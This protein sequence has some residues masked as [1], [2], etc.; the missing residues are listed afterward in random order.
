MHSFSNASLKKILGLTHIVA[1]ISGK[2]AA[3][4]TYFTNT[5]AWYYLLIAFIAAT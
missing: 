1:Y 5:L 4:L 3:E 2:E